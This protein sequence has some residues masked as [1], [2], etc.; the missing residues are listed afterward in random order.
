MKML[1]V[2]IILRM[3]KVVMPIVHALGAKVQQCLA[4]VTPLKMQDHYHQ[5]C[6]NVTKSNK[7]LIQFSKNQRAN[8]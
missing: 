4:H 2:K 8:N 6:S 3:K 5:L 1:I 7:L